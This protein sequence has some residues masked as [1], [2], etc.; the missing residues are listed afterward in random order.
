MFHFHPDSTW[1]K[2][3]LVLI[4]GLVKP[5]RSLRLPSG[6]LTGASGPQEGMSISVIYVGDYWVELYSGSYCFMEFKKVDILWSES[7][8]S[9]K[10]SRGELYMKVHLYEHCKSGTGWSLVVNKC[11]RIMD[12]IDWNRSHPD[13]MHDLFCTY[14]IDCSWEYFLRNLKVAVS[15]IGKSI[16]P[17][18]LL[19]VADCLT[20]TGQFIGLNAKGIA[21]QRDLVSVPSPFTQ[22]CF[23]SPG[24]CFIKAAKYGA[25]DGL[26]GVLNAAAWGK[27][28]P[29]G[30]GGQFDIIYSGKVHEFS[31][32]LDIYNT[33]SGHLCPERQN[34]KISVPP[35]TQKWMSGKGDTD[36]LQTFDSF[37]GK[38]PNNL[39]GL[40]DLVMLHKNLQEILHR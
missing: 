2:I 19:L 16:L 4:L 17:E 27:E 9:D 32:T 15:D 18:H 21:K 38:G 26:L 12:L 11:L 36:V 39:K 6:V 8:I 25:E 24:P 29:L 5:S 7:N 30:T 35:T 3:P 28:V 13:S 40:S 33:L 1:Y 22:A 37:I 34:V 20:V 31:E 10:A 14:G 23:S